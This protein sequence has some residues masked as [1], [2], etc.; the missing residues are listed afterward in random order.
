LYRDHKS[1][2]FTY[3]TTIITFFCVKN[4][5]LYEG[6]VKRVFDAVDLTPVIYSFRLILFVTLPFVLY[7]KIIVTLEY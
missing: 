1:N 5:G 3:H 7:L 2:F 6:H 4:K